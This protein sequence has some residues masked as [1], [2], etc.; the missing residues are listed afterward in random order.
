VNSLRGQLLVASPALV[1][2]NFHRTVVLIAEH[3][4]EGALGF[5]LN[6]PSEAAVTDVVPVLDPVVDGDETIHLGGP[7]ERS[8][9]VLLAEFDDPS[10]AARLV[11]ADVGFLAAEVEGDDEPPATRR[12]RV[13]AGHSGWGPGQLEAEVDRDDWIVEPAL[14]NDVFCEQPERLWSA[15]LAR[16]GGQFALIARMPLDPS[17]N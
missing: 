2:P 13:F 4:D 7:V 5:V 10:D 1:D 8:G 16:K 17:M 14:P 6:R 3:T 12:V 9:V 15:V 11:F